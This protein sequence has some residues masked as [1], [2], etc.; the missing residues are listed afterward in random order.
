MPDS[1]MLHPAART[2]LDVRTDATMRNDAAVRNDVAMRNDAPVV[3]AAPAH[4]AR[5]VPPAAEGEED[6]PDVPM[7]HGV[8]EAFEA[9]DGTR[10]GLLL[11]A[12]HASN[13]LPDGYPPAL[14]LAPEQFGRHI[15]YDIG[16]EGVVRQLAALL[17]VP[18]LLSR[19]SRL[20]IDPNR[21]EDDPTLIMRLSDGAV[22]PGNAAVDAAERSR[23][24]E[25]YW[26]PYDRAVADAIASLASRAD[27][28]PVILSVHSFTHAWRGVPRPWH[29]G[30]L[31]DA[32]TRVSDRLIGA[33]R[34]Q[35]DLVVGDNEPYD[36][37]L[38]GDM[39]NRQAHVRGLPHAL[40]EIRQ[41]LIAAEDGQREWAERLAPAL[42]ALERDP[43]IHAVRYHASRAL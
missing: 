31:R 26:R 11:L 7:P 25:T 28:P 39:M 5:D 34:A 35:G 43:A 14:G 30:L 2:D 37:A 24:L 41:D 40:I 36:G 4:H 33:L 18:A 15:A 21:G 19:F 20:L 3:P 1:D 9:V 6:A 22:V 27:A 29:V 38:G 12:D 17:D 42:D 13:R 16:V 32:D 10:T 8:H 23:R